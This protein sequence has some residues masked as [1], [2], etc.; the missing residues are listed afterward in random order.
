MAAVTGTANPSSQLKGGVDGGG[1]DDAKV[2]VM[3]RVGASPER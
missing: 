1:V 3:A 2:A